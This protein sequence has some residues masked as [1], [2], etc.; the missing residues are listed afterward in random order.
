MSQNFQFEDALQV[1]SDRFSEP[2]PDA[3][4]LRMKFWSSESIGGASRINGMVITRG[5]L[6]DYNA[7]ADMG[8]DDWAWD[9][10]E[11]CFRK[12]ENAIAH[13][14]SKWRSH[15]SEPDPVNKILLGIIIN[16]RPCWDN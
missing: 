16:Y 12:S 8:L 11:P 15:E 14:E 3:K 2:V 13:P 9:R 1:V 5:P 6:G 7:W 10:V 4:G